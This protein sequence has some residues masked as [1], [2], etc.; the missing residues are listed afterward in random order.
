[1]VHDSAVLPSPEQGFDEP[2]ELAAFLH[3]V[4]WG[5]IA[6]ADTTALQAPFRSG[7]Q[8]EDYQLAPVVRALSMPRTNLLIAD[9]VGLGKTIEAGLVMQELFL[10]HRART[11]MIVCPAGLTFQW[12]D[13]MREKFGLD[14]RIVDTDLLKKLRRQRGLYVNPWTHY[15]RLIV[16]V[17]WLKRDRPMRLLREVLP[18]TP[19]YPRA[20]DLLVVDEVHSCAPSGRGKYAVDSLRTKAIRALAP[21][22]EH[23]LF[24]SATPHNGYRTLTLVQTLRANGM[25][26]NGLGCFAHR[27]ANP[28]SDHPQGRACDIMFNPHSPP[29]VAE[30]TQVANWLIDHQPSLGIHYLIWQ[31]RYWPADNPAWATYQSSAYGCPNSSNLTGC[32]YDHI[33]IS[34][35]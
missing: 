2:A 15:P 19:R 5:A 22:C 32:H 35:Y 7:I 34:M 26:G 20:F 23:R 3:A 13:E 16:S 27:P 1:M 12:R 28:N 25:T 30:G 31:G 10:R 9:D 17:D 14:F 24:L 18:V 6:S 11:M 33:H 21:H 8:I 4:R 29:S